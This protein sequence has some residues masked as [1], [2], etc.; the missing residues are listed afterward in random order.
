MT[1]VAIIRFDFNGQTIPAL[2]ASVN[3]SEKQDAVARVLNSPEMA[4]AP[5]ARDFLRYVVGEEIGGRADLLKGYTIATEALGR[6]EAFD[7]DLQSAVRVQAKRLREI[8]G[9]YYGGSGRFDPVIIEIP[10]GA[11]VPVFRRRARA[12]PAPR[13]DASPAVELAEPPLDAQE[14]LLEPP[15]PASPEP[16]LA[17]G[18]R[19]PAAGS[20]A[21]PSGPPLSLAR[22]RSPSALA[23][24]AGPPSRTT[25]GG[26]I[27]PSQP[28]P[29]STRRSG[30][31]R[32]PSWPR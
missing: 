2:G 6:R 1:H 24:A 29:R 15:K 10:L 3:A 28:P 12:D 16:A 13:P 23:P 5:R 7:A 26:V 19:R 32:T 14:P 4:A 31:A 18:Q 8:L 17:R 25:T 27:S 22:R 11:Y 30:Q 20:S 21:P 9:A